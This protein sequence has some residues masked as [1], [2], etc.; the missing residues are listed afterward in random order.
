MNLV[1]HQ[2][3]CMMVVGYVMR[4]RTPE[5]ARDGDVYGE[6][7]E[8]RAM[9]RTCTCEPT[10]VKWENR[11]EGSIADA[12]RTGSNGDVPRRGYL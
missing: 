12:S 4:I 8:N 2:D 5:D 3:D 6:V 1:L 10:V 11:V 9:P 7:N